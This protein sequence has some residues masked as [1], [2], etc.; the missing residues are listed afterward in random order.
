[1]RTLARGK[2]AWRQLPEAP[3]ARLRAFGSL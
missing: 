3:R 2:A 1:V